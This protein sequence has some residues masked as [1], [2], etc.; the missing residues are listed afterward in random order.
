MKRNLFKHQAEEIQF[1]AE[2]IRS[3]LAFLYLIVFG[4]GFIYLLVRI[5]LTLGS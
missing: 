3:L 5:I 4:V 2:L 1:R